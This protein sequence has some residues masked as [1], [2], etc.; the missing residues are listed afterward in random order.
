M[1]NANVIDDTKDAN[2]WEAYCTAYTCRGTWFSKMVFSLAADYFDIPP[3]C[4]LLLLQPPVRIRFLIQ[5]IYDT[6]Y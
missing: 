5:K 1:A 4:L 2:G 6:F 3:V